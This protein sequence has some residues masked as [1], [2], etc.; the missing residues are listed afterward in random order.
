MW[1]CIDSRRFLLPVL[2][3]AGLCALPATARGADPD[4]LFRAFNA[5]M[6]A[7]S[8]REA[9]R[10][11]RQ[12]LASSNTSGW[13]AA[14]LNCLG[15]AVAAQ[16]RYAEAAAQYERGLKIPLA[17]SNINRAWIPNNLGNTYRRLNKLDAAETALLRAKTEFERIRGTNSV[18]V[19]TVLE[20]LGWIEYDRGQ[21]KKA[22]QYHRRSLAVRAQQLGQNASDVGSAGN[23]LGAALLEQGRYDE[24][25][26]E[27]QKALAIKQRVK[28]D[29]DVAVVRENLGILADKQGDHAGA[30][31][32][33]QECVRIRERLFGKNSAA[34]AHS[35]DRLAGSLEKAG[36]SDE[37]AAVRRRNEQV[38][39]AT[40]LE[41]VAAENPFR[42]GQKVQVKTDRANVMDGSKPIATLR[43]GMQLDVT[44]VNGPWCAVRIVVAGKERSGWVESKHLTSTAAAIVA[45]KPVQLN[46]EFNSDDGG[47]RVKLPQAPTQ[48]KQTVNGI[49]TIAYTAETPQGTFVV[50]YFNLPSGYVL[51]YDTSFK[52]FAG[53]RKARIESQDAVV[54]AGGLSGRE[55]LM[56]LPNGDYSRLR[57]IAVGRRQYQL[58]LEGRKDV[59]TSREAD[60]FFGSFRRH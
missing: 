3:I 11:A 56:R 54:M 29:Y 33:F 28:N 4:Q 55:A 48:T 53:A 17:S 57:L 34:V 50:S 32:Q 36:R 51:T 58:V 40:A 2:V 60:A 59:V 7:D 10:T 5:Q 12:L 46:H 42:A 31:E 15:R 39:Q 8:Y 6:E 41:P 20:N 44:Q 25:R 47:F 26:Q 18:E 23:A 24:S 22:E 1:P 19:G 38:R 45:N 35:L 52:A 21:Y 9:E 16:G 13:R 37:L 49:D 14:A 43:Q 30:I 27:L